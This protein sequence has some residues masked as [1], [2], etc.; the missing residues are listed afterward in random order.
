MRLRLLLLIALLGC[1]PA[2]PATP[3]LPSVPP[4]PPP[5][6]EVNAAIIGGE[7]TDVRGRV[8]PYAEVTVSAADSSCRKRLAAIGW[9]ADAGGR[10]DVTL[11]AGVGPPFHGCVI[12]EAR[13]GG[14][15]GQATAPATF[16]ASKEERVPVRADVVLREPELLSLQEAERLVGLLGEAIE[17][18]DRGV[19]MDLARYVAGGPE[20][21]RV[22]VEQYRQLLGTVV[23]IR[24]VATEG[25]DGNRHVDYRRVA[26]EIAG[27]SGRTAA[28]DVH[29]GELTR[30]HGLLLDYGLRS[31]RFVNAYLRAISSGDAMMLARILSPD[32]IDF[33][34]EAASEI[35][36]R[37]RARF[38]TGTLRAD[39]VDADHR[40]NTIRWRIRGRTL[41]GGEA[42]ETLDL[43]TGDGLIGVLTGG[44]QT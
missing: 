34:V 19:G 14:A 37:Y 30:L 4:P 16:T 13:S 5:E 38:D 23:T 29:Q 2:P 17:G 9:L 20:A 18:A 27:S 12:V 21:A 11:G 28:V 10:Y 26:F 32:D 40:A 8:V 39:F 44:G 31:Q 1:R 41:A 36:L 25:F 15:M 43:I 22:A 24:R 42:S 6:R 35:I 33:P 3:P 7:V